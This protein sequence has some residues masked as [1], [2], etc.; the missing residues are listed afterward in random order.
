MRTP[1][2]V[3]NNHRISSGKKSCNG[4]C[5]LERNIPHLCVGRSSSV[6]NCRCRSIVLSARC[7]CSNNGCSHRCRL[8]D[9]N[10]LRIT[11]SGC[12]GNSYS[13][14]SRRKSGCV[15]SVLRR[16]CVPR[17]SIRRSATARGRIC[18]AIGSSA[19]GYVCLR[20]NCCRG[21]V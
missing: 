15:L 9:G 6:W 21:P 11:A 18:R 16:S 17:I 2:R 19:A 5:G 1:V 14:S 7:L 10:C 4:L 20:I 13:I 3:S 8:R 12:I